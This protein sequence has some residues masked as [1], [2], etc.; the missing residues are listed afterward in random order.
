MIRINDVRGFFG[1]IAGV[2]EHRN[3]PVDRA[4]SATFTDTGET[5]SFQFSRRGLAL[6]AEKQNLDYAMSLRE[7]TSVIF[8]SHPA[9]LVPTPAGLSEL[10]P[11]YFP[12]WV[13]DRS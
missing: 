2:L 3:G 12:I 11:I 1:S 6:G 7:W 9:R 13:L 4:L 10:F 5:L 8:G